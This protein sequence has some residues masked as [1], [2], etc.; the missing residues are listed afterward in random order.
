MASI[1]KSEAGRKE[2]LGRY[3][4]ILSAWPVENRQYSIPTSYGETFV[5]ESGEKSNPPLMLLHGGSSNSFCWFGDVEPLSRKFN[6]HAVDIIGEPGLSASERPDYKSGA[7]AQWLKEVIQGLS[8]KSASVVG[9]SLGGW[10]GLQV[11][12]AFPELVDKLILLCPGGLAPVQPG[13]LWKYLLYSVTGKW[14]KKKIQKLINGG[15][16]PASISPGM[17]RAMEFMSV[18]TRNYVPKWEK[19]PILGG[20]KLSRLTMP[21]LLIYGDR[22]YLLDATK[23][24]RHLQDWAPDATVEILPDTGHVVTGQ[25]SRIM[26]FMTG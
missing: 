5:I 1:Y 2:V 8:L 10:M 6:V 23:S 9:L 15:K 16:T 24:A 25:S 14:G 20:E 18:I 17:E 19:L 12:T 7:Y 13:F 3:R 22:D 21:V 26:D 4:Q 11:S